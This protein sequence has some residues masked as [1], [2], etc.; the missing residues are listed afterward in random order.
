MAREVVFGPKVTNFAGKTLQPV[1]PPN[2]EWKKGLN[3]PQNKLKGPFRKASFQ[4]P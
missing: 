3:G 1:G 2:W 4:T